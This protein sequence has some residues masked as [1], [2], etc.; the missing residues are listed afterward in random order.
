MYRGE[1]SNVVFLLSADAG[2]DGK[3]L[4]EIAYC[5]QHANGGYG[6]H[7]LPGYAGDGVTTCTGNLFLHEMYSQNVNESEA[8]KKFANS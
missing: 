5:A 3:C 4:A 1:I 8:P 7:C 6:C 2:C